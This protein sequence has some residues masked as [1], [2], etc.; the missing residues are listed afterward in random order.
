MENKDLNINEI[1]VI[2][3]LPQL[4]YKL[5]KVG[6]YLDEELS[7]IKDIV[8]SEESKQEVKKVRTNIN[9]VLKQFE[10]KRKEVKAKCLE[11]YNLF[12]EKYEQE[13]KRKLTTASEE[14][15]VK[16]DEIETNQLA[17]KE[18]ELGNFIE[19]HVKANHLENLLSNVAQFVRLAGLKVN[20]S[21][22]L[23][24]LKDGA[25]EFVDKVAN[26]VKLIELE[27]QYSNEILLEYQNNGLD[28]TKAK[29]DVIT[30]HKQLEELAKQR[31]VVQEVVKEEEQV[32]EVVETITAPKEVIEE[33]EI[34][35]CQFKV[36]G[37]ITQIKAIKNF[38]NELGVSY[39]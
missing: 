39:E 25:K 11:E 28:Y 8:V 26:E 30:K 3:Q 5:E 23:K 4:F 31:E 15:K 20:L 13:V 2:E 24:S 16:I 10:D 18:I 14:L 37:T 36:K 22:S 34:L 35:E 9:N 38:L 29:L 21:T 6:E 27:E 17:E 7:S 1:I 12:E 33:T 32:Q 19:E